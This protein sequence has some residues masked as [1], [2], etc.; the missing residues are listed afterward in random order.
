MN[1]TTNIYF[2]VTL[3]KILLFKIRNILGFILAFNIEFFV[4]ELFKKSFILNK[5]FYSG[6]I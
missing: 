6:D 3:S 4:L 2:K 5:D 1:E